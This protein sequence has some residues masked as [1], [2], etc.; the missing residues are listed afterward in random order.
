MADPRKK[1]KTCKGKYLLHLAL[2][3]KHTIKGETLIRMRF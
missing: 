3:L 1:T 2:G